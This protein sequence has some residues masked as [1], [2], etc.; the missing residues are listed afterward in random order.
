MSLPHFEVVTHS[1]KWPSQSLTKT[2]QVRA[3]FCYYSLEGICDLIP[4]PPIW[5]LLCEDRKKPKDS[6]EMKVSAEKQDAPYVT[7]KPF[8]PYQNAN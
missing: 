6:E 4:R 5:R 1:P 7:P 8:S 3:S 2:N